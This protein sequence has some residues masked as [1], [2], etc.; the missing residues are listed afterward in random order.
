MNHRSDF[1]FSA[2]KIKLDVE[3]HDIVIEFNKPQVIFLNGIL[4]CELQFDKNRTK[5]LNVFF[6]K[7]F[8]LKI[9]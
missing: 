5:I 1:D 8:L 4:N 9:F 2:P 3:L 6:L 7:F